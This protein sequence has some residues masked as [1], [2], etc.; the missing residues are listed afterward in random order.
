MA[1][2][3]ELNDRDGDSTAVT[4]GVNE[5]QRIAREEEELEKSETAIIVIF[6]QHNV[7]PRRIVQC[8][9]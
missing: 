1:G 3:A 9:Q 2:I 5:E 4:C 6:I 7:S 8:L